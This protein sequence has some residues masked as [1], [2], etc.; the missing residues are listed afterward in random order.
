VN[1]HIGENIVKCRKVNGISQGYLAK[2]VGIS[3]QG[4]LKIEKGIVSPRVDTLEKIMYALCIT[5]NQLFGIEQ[6][7]EDNISI[8]EKLRKLQA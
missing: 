8:V 4:L 3:S 5:P 2:R 1:K 6:I 7:T